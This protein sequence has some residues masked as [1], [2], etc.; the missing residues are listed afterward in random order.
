M[1]PNKL[2]AFTPCGQLY[3]YNLP[4]NFKN[5]TNAD[6]ASKVKTLSFEGFITLVS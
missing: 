3:I 5:K 4:K 2:G 6:L 1:T